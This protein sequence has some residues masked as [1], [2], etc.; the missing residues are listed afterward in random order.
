MSRE[1]KFRAWDPR[2]KVMVHDFQQNIS[3]VYPGVKL[4][5]SIHDAVYTVGMAFGT[6]EQYTGLKDYNGKEV[7]EGDILQTFFDGK[8][9][10]RIVE[11]VVLH[12]GQFRFGKDDPFGLSQSRISH[13]VRIGSIHE[14]PELLEARNAD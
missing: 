11:P 4:G 7:Y 10:D 14:N 6:L 12:D 5:D 1:I 8:P 9:V 13:M 3:D 2:K